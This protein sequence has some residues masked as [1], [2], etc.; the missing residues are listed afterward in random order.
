MDV[1]DREPLPAESPLWGVENLILTPHIGGDMKDFMERSAAV[2]AEN[3]G[4][5][6]RGEPLL[7]QVD[8][9]RGY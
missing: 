6:L 8:L 7:N 5:Y 2:F 3:I 9:A 4:R 1:F